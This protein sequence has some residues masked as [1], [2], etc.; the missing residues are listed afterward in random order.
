[1]ADQ[2]TTAGP[3]KRPRHHFVRRVVAGIAARAIWDSVRA[4]LTELDPL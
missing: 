3:G 1:M 2:D 4:A